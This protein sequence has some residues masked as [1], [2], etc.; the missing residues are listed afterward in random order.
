MSKMSRVVIN[1]NFFIVDKQF[2][3]NITMGTLVKKNNI[4][5]LTADLQIGGFGPEKLHRKL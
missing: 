3:T 5:N 4:D 1:M 2:S